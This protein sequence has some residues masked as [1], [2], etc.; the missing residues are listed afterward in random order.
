MP[1]NKQ[2]KNIEIETNEIIKSSSCFEAKQNLLGFFDLL[3]K[4]DKR[5]NP[6]LYKK[7]F[8]ENYKDNRSSDNTD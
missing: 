8:N 4:I 5:N 7:Q 2:Q 1:K 6:Q 3:L